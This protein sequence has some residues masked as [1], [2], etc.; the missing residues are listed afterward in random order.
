MKGRDSQTRTREL[1]SRAFLKKMYA[2]SRLVLSLFP[3]KNI[4][5]GR[6]KRESVLNLFLG[7]ALHKLDVVIPP[8]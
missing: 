2:F 4:L 7:R 3:E 5:H 1:K 8:L 6:E